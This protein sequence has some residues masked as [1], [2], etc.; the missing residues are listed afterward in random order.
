MTGTIT[1]DVTTSP[2]QPSP[3]PGPGA[4]GP[5]PGGAV[6]PPRPRGRVARVFLGPPEDPRWAR[7]ALWALLLTTAALYLWNLSASGYAND[8]YAAA[9]KSGTESW[10][11]WLFGSLDSGNTITVDKPPASLWV[12]VLFTR[13]F[14]F[15][16]L[17]MLLPQA[18]MGV[19]TVA[20]LYAAVRRWSGP[21]AGLVAGALLAATPVAALMFRFNNPDALLTL[22]VTAASYFVIRAIETPVGRKA[23]RWLLF[24]GVAI[25]FAFLTKM[26]QG[27]LVLPAF[28]LAYLWA[29]RSGLWTRI[30]H[31]LAAG[32]A[33][34]ISA[35]WYVALVALWPADSRPYI[36]GS[37]TNSLWELA[38]GYNGLGRIFGN[39]GGGGGGP[40][41]GGFGGGGFGGGGFG[42]GGFGGSTGIGRMFGTSFGSEISWLIPAALIGLVAGLWFTRR[43]PRTDK[44]RAALLLWGGSLIVTALVFSFMA[45]TIHP[46]YAIALAPPIAAVVAISGRELWRGRS[47]TVVRGVLAA[48]IAV[49]GVWSFILLGRDASWLPWLRWI[50]LIGSVAGAVL[51]ALSTQKLRRFA[52]IGLLV[53]SLTALSGTTAYTLAT[54]ATPHSGSIPTS[55]PT[56]SAI[57]G[58]GGGFARGGTLPGGTLPGG[59]LPGGTLPSGTLP[60]G[61]LPGGTLP[62]GTLPGGTIPGGTGGAAPGAGGGAATTNSELVALLEATTTRWA[63]ATVGAQSAAGYILGTDKAVM[64]IGGFTGSDPAPTLAQFQQYVADGDISYFISG[65]GMG[66]GAGGPGGGSGSG[67]EITAWVQANFTATTVGGATVYDLT[68]PQ[69]S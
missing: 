3:A 9:V 2:G 67:S 7:P 66:G 20:L 42:G 39:S 58:P 63:A 1:T 57:G 52:V 11:A 51:L 37:E 61:T 49:T 46:Y 29:G 19:G 13:I 41:G 55:G 27:L 15:S 16:S 45:G 53:G 18:L 60:G 36:G 56:G 59:T 32:A 40:G 21:A 8:Y 25:G 35:G 12:M 38:I 17:A 64:G 22:L 34:V 44:I 31:L 6:D 47:N 26:L 28:A 30:W 10:K 54:A 23:L 33:V 69:T 5:P 14:G 65:G 43:F 24:A 50:V 48:M 68:S 62:G 4:Y